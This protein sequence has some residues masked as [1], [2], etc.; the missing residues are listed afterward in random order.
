[1][2]NNKKKESD[3]VLGD[4]TPAESAFG[5]QSI[6][7]D[8]GPTV[9]V[10]SSGLSS[11]M[12]AVEGYL[13]SGAY[14]W[15]SSI[16]GREVNEDS[17]KIGSFNGNIIAVAADGLG[18]E[19]DGEL[20]SEIICES[21]MKCGS[22]GVFP[23]RETVKEGFDAA[24]REL[25]SKQK[26]RFHMK[27]TAVYL[28]I[29]DNRAIWAHIGDSR[30]YHLYG[31]KLCEYTMDHSASQMAVLLG[32]IT[33][34]QIPADPGRSR[35]LRAMGS[36]EVK[37]DIH[38]PVLLKTGVH[39]FLLCTDGLWEY[40]SDEVIAEELSR[41]R[42]PKEFIN[43]LYGIKT[44]KSDRNCDNSSAVAVFWRV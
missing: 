23:D 29:N 15:Y 13:Q 40:L 9:S 1:M 44:S 22:D 39:C 27:S 31:G 28:C 21:L 2:F 24:N 25:L 8:S 43:K 33:R 16:G 6:F 34:E 26:N 20:A 12:P 38:D 32:E 42:S 4:H 30:L 7:E 3:G 17:V 10:F 19:G 18:G 35:L 37:P 36:E 41:A 14:A 11:L 5:N